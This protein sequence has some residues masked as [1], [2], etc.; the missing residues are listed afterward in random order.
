MTEAVTVALIGFAGA[1]LG[2]GLGVITSAKLT[3]YRLEQL[4]KQVS[5]HN[6]LIERVYLLEK[7]EALLEQ[8]IE[9]LYKQE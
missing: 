7:K 5:L 9:D 4:E 8:H 2:S 6:N 3:N 1:V